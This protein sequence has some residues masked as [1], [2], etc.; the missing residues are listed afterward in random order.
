MGSV[1]ENQP[2]AD[3]HEINAHISETPLR[4]CIFTAF[5]WP[6]AASRCWKLGHT[7]FC[8]TQVFVSMIWR[9]KWK[10]STSQR[11]SRKKQSLQLNPRPGKACTFLKR[12]ISM[13]QCY[14]YCGKSSRS[15]ALSGKLPIPTKFLPCSSMLLVG[16]DANERGASLEMTCSCIASS[17]RKHS[18]SC[19]TKKTLVNS[20][21]SADSR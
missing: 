1:A 7:R 11:P 13:K 5:H 6:T 21:L 9:V 2:M 17:G 15:S 19:H 4:S 3:E 10:N 18:R 16:S 8:N 14:S 12:S 20:E